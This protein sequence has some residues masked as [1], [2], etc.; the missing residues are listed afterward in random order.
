PAICT[1]G[2]APQGGSPHCAALTRGRRAPDLPPAGVLLPRCRGTQ[3]LRNPTDGKVKLMKLKLTA[4]ASAALL[5][6]ALMAGTP[7]VAQGT[8]DDAVTAQLI[9]LG[10]TPDDWVMTEEQVL[11]L[12]NVLSSTDSDDEK[13]ARVRNIMELED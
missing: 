11:E 6:L 5:S 12:Q 8:L 2:A 10:F 7:A 9:S 4:A 13:S 1:G 3:V